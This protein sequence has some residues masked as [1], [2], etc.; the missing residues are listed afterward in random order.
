MQIYS[1]VILLHIILCF[2]LFSNSLFAQFPPPAG[3]PGSTA[4]H[5]DSSI[6]IDWADDCVVLRGFINQADTSFTYNGNNKA[7]Y[8]SYLYA[9]GPSDEY[10]VSLGDQGEAILSFDPP[11]IDGPG[12]DFAVFENSFGDLFLEFAFVEVSSD[13]QHYVRFPSVSLTPDSVQVQTFGTLD[14]TRINNLAGKYRMGFGTPFDL[15]ELKDSAGITINHIT[16]VRIKDTGGCIDPPF[17]TYDSQGHKINDPW[18]TPFDTG[19]FDLDA[20]GV[21]HNTLQG[22]CQ[23]INKADARCYPNPFSDFFT[24]NPGT[25]HELSYKLLRSDGVIVKSGSIV[26]K[27]NVRTDDLNGGLYLLQLNTDSGQTTS[28]KLI[29]IP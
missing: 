18:P 14:A 10:V 26:T 11:I 3:Q 8:G 24:I 27:T 22:L 12:A 16:H 7:T 21:I 4:I 1:R 29:Q 13:G 20:V 17:I 2:P 19:G 28:L 9:S 5:H 23:D 25:C 6:F 15:N